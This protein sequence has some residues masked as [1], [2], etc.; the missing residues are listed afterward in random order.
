MDTEQTTHTLRGVQCNRTLF[1]LCFSSSHPRV[2]AADPDPH[3]SVLC[4][5]LSCLSGDG[6]IL[7]RDSLS[8]QTP[9][10]QESNLS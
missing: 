5:V 2:R 6:A 3:T 7:R 10:H 8:P 1:S 9:S 4:N